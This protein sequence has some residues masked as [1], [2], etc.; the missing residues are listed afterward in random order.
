[1]GCPKGFSGESMV[2][3]RWAPKTKPCNMLKNIKVSLLK[4]YEIYYFWS[5][6]LLCADGCFC[7]LSVLGGR[8]GVAT[9]EVESAVSALRLRGFASKLF[10]ACG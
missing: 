5:M 4:M 3:R 10:D 9:S 6:W 1:M 2:W 8:P 7:N